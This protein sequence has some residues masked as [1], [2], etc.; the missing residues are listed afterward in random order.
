MIQ[1]PRSIAVYG[2]KNTYKGFTKA[3]DA[4]LLNPFRNQNKEW[5]KL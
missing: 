1:L 4:G 3:M 2:L 5:L